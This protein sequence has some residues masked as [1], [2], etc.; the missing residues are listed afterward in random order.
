MFIKVMEIIQLFKRFV[1]RFHSFI[2]FSLL[3]LKVEFS[4]LMLNY[5]IHSIFFM[6]G[7]QFGF[8]TYFVFRFFFV[9]LC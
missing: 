2:I 7:A 1:K 9:P 6:F 8:F 3:P 5:Y 4:T